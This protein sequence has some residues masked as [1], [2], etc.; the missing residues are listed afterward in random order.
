MDA[1]IKS[2]LPWF[3]ALISAAVMV[4]A[5][6][7]ANGVVAARREDILVDGS[8]TGAVPRWISA[9]YLAGSVGI[10]ISFVWSFSISWWAPVVAVLLYLVTALVP[11][12]IVAVTRELGGGPYKKCTRCAA[13]R[14]IDYFA[15]DKSAADGHSALCVACAD[16]AT[17]ARVQQ[18]KADFT[19]R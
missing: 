5:R 18:L 14:P 8:T 12:R 19:K 2:Y 6:L 4:A 7:V 17:W 10:F 13:V 3:A 16:P 1:V 11:S 15:L 9:T